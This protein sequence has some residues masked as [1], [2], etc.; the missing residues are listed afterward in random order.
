[1]GRD[2][3]IKG[4]SH[5]DLYDKKQYVEPAVDKLTDFVSTHLTTD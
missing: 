1:M 3:W 4:A 5:V 2:G